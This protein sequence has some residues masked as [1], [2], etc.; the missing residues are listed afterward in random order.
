MEGWDLHLYDKIT[1]DLAIGN[2]TQGVG[3]CEDFEVI[4]IAWQFELTVLSGREEL[5]TKCCMLLKGNAMAT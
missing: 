1:S 4:H 3:T 5:E 2:S